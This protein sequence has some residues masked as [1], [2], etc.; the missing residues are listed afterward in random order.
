MADASRTNPPV[1]DWRLVLIVAAWLAGRGARD[2]FHQ[3]LL[4]FLGYWD[5]VAA[6]AGAS[7]ALLLGIRLLVKWGW[8]TGLTIGVSFSLMFTT[9]EEIKDALQPKFGALAAIAAAFVPMLCV[10]IV[11]WLLLFRL[12]RPDRRIPG[13]TNTTP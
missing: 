9:F 11:T 10:G 4:P 1:M 2:T 8:R 3:D 6:V 5:S 13:G 12:L 7:A